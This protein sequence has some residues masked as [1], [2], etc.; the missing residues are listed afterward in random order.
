M[1][2]PNM[3]P[4]RRTFVAITALLLCAYSLLNN[5]WTPEVVE[6]KRMTVCELSSKLPEYRGKR[7]AVR[8]VYYYGLRQECPNSCAGGVWPSFLNLVTVGE[9]GSNI[10]EA[11]THLEQAVERKAKTGRRFE[12]WVTVV[13][14]LQTNAQRSAVGLCDQVG[15]HTFGYGHLGAFPG[16]I[17]VRRFID[18]E[19]RVNANSPY[20]YGNMYHGA[21]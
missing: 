18:I 9:T 20:D 8:G 2:N 14:D 12:I 10:W 6:S 5:D 11:L 15:S 21:L 4:P 16:Q 7:V 17:V 3:K 1:S 13:G 19:V